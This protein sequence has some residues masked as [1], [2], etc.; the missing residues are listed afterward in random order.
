MDESEARRIFARTRIAAAERVLEKG[1]AF[2]DDPTDEKWAEFVQVL[3]DISRLEASPLGRQ[4]L[5][6][7]DSA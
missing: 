5:E 6:R 3:A 2:C 1:R 7:P 4:S